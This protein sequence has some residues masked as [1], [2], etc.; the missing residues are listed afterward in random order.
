MCSRQFAAFVPGVAALTNASTAAT[1]TSSLDQPVPNH[2]SHRPVRLAT[3]S[4]PTGI[5]WPRYCSAA[6]G[7]WLILSAFAW[8]RSPSEITNAWL[9]GVLMFIVAFWTIRAP[10][11]RWLNTLLALWL[12]FSTLTFPHASR[13]TPWND[14]IVALAA[15]VFSLFPNPTSRAG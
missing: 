8:R 5:P 3:A 2:I 13:L 10:A 4:P 14:G 9:V 7:A 1:G 12:G 15:F 6:L 11:M